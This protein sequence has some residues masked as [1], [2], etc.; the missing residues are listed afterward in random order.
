[1][2]LFRQALPSLSAPLIQ[3]R[4]GLAIDIML[5]SLATGAASCRVVDLREPFLVECVWPALR[6]LATYQGRYLLG[7]SLARPVLVPS[8]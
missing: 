5:R 4:M 6:A 3:L 2:P 8:E 1:M 7:T